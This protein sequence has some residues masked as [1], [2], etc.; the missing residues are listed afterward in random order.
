VG[1]GLGL[2]WVGVAEWGM[3][4][5]L[6]DGGGGT[7]RRGGGGGGKGTTDDGSVEPSFP[8]WPG[9]GRAVRWSR[10]HALLSNKA[11]GPCAAVIY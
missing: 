5:A 3:V 2:T 9:A 6:D 10:T 11:Q 8:I 7:T 4:V 1:K